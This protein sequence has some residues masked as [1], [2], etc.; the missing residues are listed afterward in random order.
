MKE[1]PELRLQP[2][3]SNSSSWSSHAQTACFADLLLIVSILNPYY[4]SMLE[5]SRPA[6]MIKP[7]VFF[8][9][10]SSI[11]IQIYAYLGDFPQLD[12]ICHILRGGA[13]ITDG[14]NGLKPAF[15]NS[16]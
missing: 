8:E 16:L 6:P 10:S 2:N 5:T 11:D 12:K 1:E 13:G 9:R 3:S 15:S 7:F 4:P 14:A